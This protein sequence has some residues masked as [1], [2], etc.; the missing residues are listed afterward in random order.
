MRGTSRV[1]KIAELGLVWSM[2]LSAC[3]A[4]AAGLNKV[5]G[6][7]LLRPDRAGALPGGSAGRGRSLLRPDRAG[8][9]PDGSAGRGRS[10]LRPDRAHAQCWPVIKPASRGEARDSSRASPTPA[11]T[12]TLLGRS[13]RR[14]TAPPHQRDLERPRNRDEE[15]GRGGLSPLA[16][17]IATR[18]AELPGKAS[19]YPPTASTSRSPPLLSS[20]ATD[21]DG[22][23][24]PPCCCTNVLIRRTAS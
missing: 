17:I 22:L 19:A 5:S 8:A 15:V 11:Q 12:R 23:P 13:C 3:V 24:H 6:R 14:S 16:Q 20:S 18:D 7:S 2:I 10:L 21:D 1:A 4:P 9:L